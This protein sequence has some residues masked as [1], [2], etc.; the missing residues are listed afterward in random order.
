MMYSERAASQGLQQALAASCQL[1][2]IGGNMSSVDTPIDFEHNIVRVY[3]DDDTKRAYRVPD[4][5]D[6]AVGELVDELVANETCPLHDSVE[7]IELFAVF[8]TNEGNAYKQKYYSSY[9]SLHG[10][11][12]RL[13]SASQSTLNRRTSVLVLRTFARACR[14]AA[15]SQHR[16]IDS[17]ISLDYCFERISIALC[18]NGYLSFERIAYVRVAAAG[19]TLESFSS[20]SRLPAA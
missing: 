2:L 3:T 6:K 10:R 19:L 8:V 9:L 15:R 18:A 7:R 13:L 11:R 20:V 16:W 1:R 5:Q 12:S 4:L 14:L 17:K